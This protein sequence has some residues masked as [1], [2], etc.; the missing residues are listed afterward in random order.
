MQ[1]EKMTD[2]EV[3]AFADELWAELQPDHPDVRALCKVYTI[4][5]ERLVVEEARANGDMAA[6]KMIDRLQALCKRIRRE[7]AQRQ[8]VEAA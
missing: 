1:H 3:R 6:A 7:Q 4:T 5:F 8:T 2:A